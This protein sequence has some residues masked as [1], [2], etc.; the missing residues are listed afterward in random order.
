LATLLLPVIL[1]ATAAVGQVTSHCLPETRPPGM[2]PAQV[3]DAPPVH[4]RKVSLPLAHEKEKEGPARAD[5]AEIRRMLGLPT[6]PTGRPDARSL[7]TMVPEARRVVEQ[8]RS[9]DHRSAAEAGDRLLRSPAQTFG[10]YTWDYLANATAW[11]HLNRDRPAAAA[12][13]HEL[14]AGRIGDPDVSA[15]HGMAAAAIRQAAESPGGAKRLASDDGWNKAIR[16]QLVDTYKA[17]QKGVELA[18]S[19]R[20]ATRRLDNLRQAYKQ[21]RILE[22]ADPDFARQNAL[23]AFREAADS[24]CTESIPDILDDARAMHQRLTQLEKTAIKGVDWG[25]W[26]RLVRRLWGTVREA[27]R[28]CRAHDY[29]RRMGLATSRDAPRLFREA[30]G[31]LFAPGSRREIWNPRGGLRGTYSRDIRKLIPYDETLIRPM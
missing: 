13:A 5:D 9:G 14:A 2:L 3:L 21:M 4:V 8:A 22:A 17:F 20:S 16:E 1:P 27:K 11:A 31:L 25:G 15:Y 7:S 19:V 28:V 30:N 6:K 12:K 23:P 29:L 18:K 26:C 10:D 24:L